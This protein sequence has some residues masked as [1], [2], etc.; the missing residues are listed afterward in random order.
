M[1]KTPAS[2]A[3]ECSPMSANARECVRMLFFGAGVDV[4]LM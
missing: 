4:A 1:P 2:D 3:R